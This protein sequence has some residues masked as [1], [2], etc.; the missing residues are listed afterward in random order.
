[1]SYLVQ[2]ILPTDLLTFADALGLA[3]VAYT[4]VLHRSITFEHLFREAEQNNQADTFL[5]K[6]ESNHNPTHDIHLDMEYRNSK[7]VYVFV[8][9]HH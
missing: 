9:F 5:K 1:V 2:I 8:K 4:P 7:H 3:T 6:F